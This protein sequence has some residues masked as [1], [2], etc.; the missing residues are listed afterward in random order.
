M[1]SLKDHNFPIESYIGGF[2]IAE[3]VCDDLINYFKSNHIDTSPGTVGG[4]DGAVVDPKVKES[5]DLHIT[6][7]EKNAYVSQYISSLGYALAEYKKKYTILDRMSRFGLTTN[8]NIQYYKAGQ[9]YKDWHCE[10]SS[11]NKRLLV[12]MT[13]LND[14]PNGGTEFLHQNIISPAKKGLTLFWPTDW[15]HTHRGQISENHEKYIA[16]GWLN[17]IDD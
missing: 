6:P 2:Y 4:T 17:F 13:Y 14:V 12:W 7:H 1:T 8:W 15:T 3:N 11:N 16:T 10:R 5:T 9:G